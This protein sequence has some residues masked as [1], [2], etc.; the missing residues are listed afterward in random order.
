MATW[1][2]ENNLGKKGLAG[3]KVIELGAGVGY[4]SLVAIALGAN[5]VAI[6][7]G[8]AAVVDIARRNAELNF[9]GDLGRRIRAARLRWNTPDV[10]AFRGRAWDS[11]LASDCT[12]RRA[13]WGDLMQTIAALSGPRTR[14][15]L[16]VEPRSPDEV[17]GVLAAARRSGLA[18]REEPLP[19]DR[20]RDAC[21]VLCSRLFTLWKP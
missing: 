8:N 20:E 13:S 12:Y 21:G 9:P 19:V 17:D 4:V 6:T 3:S 7:D 2:L 11:I 1:H 16:E 10:D 5:E 15:I 18:F 14:A